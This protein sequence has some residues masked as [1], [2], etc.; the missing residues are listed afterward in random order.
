MKKRSFIFTNKKH[1]LI[2]IMS[3]IL[4]AISLIAFAYGIIY[5]FVKAGEVPTRF[6]FAGLLGIIYSLVGIVL[7]LYALKLKDVFHL[8]T[9]IGIILN[10]IALFLAG[11][12]LW[13]PS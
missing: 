5:S 11:F 12:L 13:L 6:G 4:G 2:S 7:A 3:A 1:P 10:V 8:F 9:V